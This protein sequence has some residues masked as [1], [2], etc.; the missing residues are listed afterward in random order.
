MRG[1]RWKDAWMLCKRDFQ[2]Y[3]IGLLFTFLFAA[4][5]AVCTLPMLGANLSKEDDSVAIRCLLDFISLVMIGNLGFVFNR[6]GRRYLA[7]D[8]HR[9][10]IVKLRTLPVELKTIILSRFM[11]LSIATLLNGTIYFLIQYVFM[12]D[13]R[14]VLPV[15]NYLVYVLA[16]MTCAVLIH[17]FYIGFEWSV[18]GKG[19]MIVVLLMMIG[20]LLI[21]I[22]VSFTGKS[23][24]VMLIQSSN[25]YALAVGV[26]SVAVLIQTYTYS[27]KIL[28]GLLKRKDLM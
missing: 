26:I 7:D 27:G 22:C 14:E 4:Y 19:Y 17:M 10:H 8:S 3:W 24:V 5:M 25:Q 15:G 16:L 20:Y 28:L 18:S 13:L 1:K 21:S 12:R 2:R 9:K 6:R 23:L 11:H